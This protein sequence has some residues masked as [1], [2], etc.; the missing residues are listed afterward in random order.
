MLKVIISP[1]KKMKIRNDILPYKNIPF[2][3]KEAEKLF[4]YMGNMSFDELKDLW[5]CSDK[6]VEENE[7][8]FRIGN[9]KQN[10]S[11]AILSYEGIQY[12]YMAPAVFEEQAFTWLEKHLRILSGFYGALS[13][14]DGVIPYRLEMQARFHKEEIDNLYD[15]WGQK[16]ADYFGK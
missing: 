2:F 7:R 12:K 5:K 16:L 3:I 9:L 10:L 13:P 15:F 6:L 4:S 8:Q 14:F 1:A 11:P